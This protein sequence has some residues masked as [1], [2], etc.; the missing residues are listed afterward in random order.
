MIF[1]SLQYFLFLP[2]ALLLY[3][4]T[5]G[6]WR[7]FVVVATSYFFYMSWLPIY[8]VLMLAL[9]TANWLLAQAM[10][11]GSQKMKK[12]L[13][14][15]GLLINL[16]CLSY[17][18][19][20]NFFI[21][22]A[23]ALINS[24]VAS[25]STNLGA[26][27]AHFTHSGS[28]I[29]TGQL[30]TEKAQALQGQV[31]PTPVFDIIL[32]L[33]IS[34]FVFEFVHY[35]IDVY[36]GDKPVKSWLEF[37]AFAA[38]F[39]S[40]IAGPIKRYQQFAQ[41][42][43][44][45]LPWSAALF[46]EGMALLM[47]GLFKKVAMADPLSLI[48]AAGFSN[49]ATLSGLDAWISTFTFPILVYLDFSG[50]TDMGRG[51]AMLMGIKLP[52]NF[53]LPLLS[54]DTGTL[55]RKWHMSLSTWLRDYVYFPLGGS[56]KGFW[57]GLLNTMIT[58]AVCGLWHGAAWT[59]ILWGVTQ[60][61]GVCI[62][63]IWME[64]AGRI[65]KNWTVTDK[66]LVFG[67][68]NF[69]LYAV[70]FALTYLYTSITWVFFRAAT[71]TEATNVISH[72]LAPGYTSILLAPLTK[73]CLVAIMGCYVVFWLACEIA[74]H[75]PHWIPSIFKS[76][77]PEASKLLFS[78]PMRYASWTAAFVLILAAR[79]TEAVPFMYFQF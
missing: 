47:R 36:R 14:I 31:L 54:A 67:Q 79:P 2:I 46:H 15:L 19:Y 21:S 5:R 73:S 71:L 50:Y 17:Y 33:G 9:T 7:H 66:G 56:K 32:P 1:S 4:K 49:S 12:P 63:R 22:N 30:L 3:W 58:M 74:R 78:T 6:V 13:F 69:F 62:N 42:L 52:D 39:P 20:T 45:P 43:H 16:G 51:S 72:L 57:A 40:Q 44:N 76:A 18:K 37:A 38:F 61:A 68:C 10:E 11:R 35:L 27:G 48:V 65:N 8:G 77:M 59:Y 26:L 41:Y 29:A 60:G 70:C 25:V 75:Q 34:F 53:M 23:I 28:A 64:Y 55:W 24:F